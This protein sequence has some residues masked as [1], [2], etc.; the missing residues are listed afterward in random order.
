MRIYLQIPIG[1]YDDTKYERKYVCGS[2]FSGYKSKTM[3]KR[4][5]IVAH[6]RNKISKFT[7]ITTEAQVFIKEKIEQII[8]TKIKPNSRMV[9]DRNMYAPY[10]TGGRD[11]RIKI[12][13][14]LNKRSH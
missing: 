3:L 7:R 6:R 13:E 8:K 4:H 11:M 9:N 12:L 5:W 2:C 10:M 14:V 1:K